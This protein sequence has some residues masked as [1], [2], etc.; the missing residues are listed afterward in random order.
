MKTVKSITLLLFTSLI[1]ASCASTQSNTSTKANDNPNMTKSGSGRDY[2]SYTNLADI[3]RQQVGVTVTGTG[4]NAT[5]Q[6][7]GINSVV[8]DTRPLYV[9]DGVELGRSYARANQAVNLA[10]IK[11]IR[12]IRDLNQLTSYGER[13]RN[14][15]IYIKSRK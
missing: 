1:I 6:I 10:D 3:L 9:Y 4:A 15:V 11:S 7:R 14:G 2:S 13:G 12:V 5:V 8:L